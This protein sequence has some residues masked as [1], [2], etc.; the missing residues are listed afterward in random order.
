MKFCGSTLPWQAH[1]KHTQHTCAEEMKRSTASVCCVSCAC[2]PSHCGTLPW[3]QSTQTTAAATHVDAHSQQN[4]GRIIFSHLFP[5]SS[6]TA[7]EM[8]RHETSADYTGSRE[9]WREWARSCDSC[10]GVGAAV[11]RFRPARWGEDRIRAR[12]QSWAPHR[13]S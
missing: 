8:W 6:G 1:S 13:S 10:E 5:T 2:T 9:S 11:P 12:V 4:G 7:A 3:R